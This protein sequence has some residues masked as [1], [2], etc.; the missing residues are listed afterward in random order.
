MGARWPRGVSRTQPLTVVPPPRGAPRGEPVA[1][2]S[3][4]AV[5]ERS[6]HDPDAFALVYDRHAAAI[7]DHVARRLGADLAEDLCA[8]TFYVAFNRRA[9]YDVGHDNARP[10]LYGIVTNLM[11]GHRRAEVRGYRAMARAGAAA[12]VGGPGEIDALLSRMDAS[13]SVRGIAGALASLSP[14]ERNVLLLHAWDDLS[15][16]DIARALGISPVTVRTRLH[17][18]RARLRPLLEAPDVT[19]G[20]R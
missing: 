8:Q 7:H 12:T 2:L 1:V 9:S 3:D 19:R 11:R 6:V 10:W 14:G 4:A 13:R 17:R 20:H 18:A 15:H 5:I 16:D